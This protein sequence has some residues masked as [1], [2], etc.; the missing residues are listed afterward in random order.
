MIVRSVRIAVVVAMGLAPA[1]WAQQAAPQ[2]ASGADSLDEV[3]VTASKRKQ[4]LL[5]VSGAISVQSGDD[6]DARR[7]QNM[8]ALF[9]V[10]PGVSFQKT[11]P[12]QSFPVIRGISTGSGLNLVTVPVGIYFGDVP[13]SDPQNPQSVIDATPIDMETVE[14]LKGP[15]GSLY[16][17]NSL[18][19]AVR[20]VFR[21]PDLN[22]QFSGNVDVSVSDVAEASSGYRV[23]GVLNLAGSEAKA[24]V[25]L[26]GW[27]SM[28]PGYVDNVTAGV[29]GASDWDNYGFRATAMW[30]PTDRFTITLIGLNQKSTIDDSFVVD[31]PTG[32]ELTRVGNPLLS[33]S[34]L[35]TSFGNLVLEYEF[36]DTLTLT[37]NT[38]YLD[39][40]RALRQDFT[41]GGLFCVNFLQLFG[42]P[43]SVPSCTQRAITTG[44]QFFQELR[45]SGQAGGRVSYV[46][47]ASFQTAETDI[48]GPGPGGIAVTSAP[49]FSAQIA[50]FLPPGTTSAQT[51][52]TDAY[53]FGKAIQENSESAVFA[54]AEFSVTPR[55]SITAGGRFW[56]NE[57]ELPTQ[58]FGGYY[59]FVLFSP[60]NWQ[61]ANPYPKSAED[62]FTPKLAV[63]FRLGDN[64]SVYALASRG[65]RFGGVNVI[66]EVGQTQQGRYNTDTLWNYEVGYRGRPTESL[67]ME[68]AAYFMDWK[69]AQ[70]QVIGSDNFQRVKNA[71]SA[72][73]K[74]VEAGVSWNVTERLR[75]R[76]AASFVDAELADPLSLSPLLTLPEG[77][78]L[79]GTPELS[80]SA[81]AEY[82]F[83]GPFDSSGQWV[84]SH[85]HVGESYFDIEQTAK[86]GGYDLVD[87]R[88]FLTR[89]KVQYSA[90]VSNL[91]DERASVGAV[92]VPV[93]SY[94]VLQPRT[95]GLGVRFDF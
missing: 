52:P 2:G 28:T 57:S 68:A 77:R 45:L 21:R 49:G 47:G 93:L 51:G 19:G 46:A 62:G 42:L 70:I 6:I 17:A 13:V 84:L 81:S 35:R 11:S 88:I 24:G 75:L 3:V 27:S 10:E 9:A 38:A 54:E 79:P 41:N 56:R 69:D 76:A 59:S 95:V 22:S 63:R 7:A 72:Q 87:F 50:P 89:G 18:A 71:A 29:N 60:G 25:R 12:E 23:S 85:S 61:L 80:T 40:K 55:V 20:Y 53:L 37:S 30:R 64:Q 5:D 48:G 92:T 43:I 65:Y 39:K 66:P 73:V 31:D 44:N 83:D 33:P 15:Q 86:I 26:V 91:T 14:I 90:F 78:A 74:G 4:R 34:S 1:A 94:S 82:S 36:S 32:E 16:G 58:Y 8:E 67:T